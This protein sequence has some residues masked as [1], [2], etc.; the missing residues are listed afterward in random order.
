M[1]FAP[2]IAREMHHADAA[3]LW[4]VFAELTWAQGV[5]TLLACIELARG[6]A[7]MSSLTNAGGYGI[8]LIL[9]LLLFSTFQLEELI[10][11]SVAVALLACVPALYRL[12]RWWFKTRRLP[13]AKNELSPAREVLRYG[14]PRAFGNLMDPATDLILPSVALS[15]GGLEQAG[16]FAAS[17]GLLRPLNPLMSA[18]N[19]ILIPDSARLVADQNHDAARS[20]AELI[21]QVAIHFGLFAAAV[22]AIWGDFALTLWL[23]PSFAGGALHVRVL[24]FS[25]L[26]VLLYGVSR[27]IIDGHSHRAI[28]T[29]NLAVAFA[30]FVAGVVLCL[31]SAWTILALAAV[32]LVSRFVLGGLSLRH[33]FKIHGVSWRSLQSLGA[34][35][36]VLLA[37]ALMLAMRWEWQA[38]VIVCVSSIILSALLYLFLMYR[39][40]APWTQVLA[41]KVGR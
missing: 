26:P 7:L 12:V 37:A 14:F 16:F 5:V 34:A 2:V 20:R 21:A 28:N 40:R 41:R 13:T 8:S 32:Y 31:Y 27:G 22:L 39:A 33:L 6:S 36:T 30:V 35:G 10:A 11:A 24:A 1:L 38:N 17:L 9:P 25:I 18:L 23:G 29:A 3:Q 19:M 15:L 4:L